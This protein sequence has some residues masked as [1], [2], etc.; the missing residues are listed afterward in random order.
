MSYTVLLWVHWR[1]RSPLARGVEGYPRACAGVPS[2][3][4][5]VWFLCK[6]IIQ[7]YTAISKL[8]ERWRN[9]IRHMSYLPYSPAMLLLLWDY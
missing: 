3:K 4:L 9:E 7:M 1:G 6:S 8:D 5:E 2:L